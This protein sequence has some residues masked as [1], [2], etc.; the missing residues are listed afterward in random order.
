MLRSTKTILNIDLSRNY[1]GDYAVE[2]IE[3]FIIYAVNP[4]I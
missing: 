2:T 3:K 1:I 4:P